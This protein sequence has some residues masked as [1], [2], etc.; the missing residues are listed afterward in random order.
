MEKKLI[1]IN[2]KLKKFDTQNLKFKELI[3]KLEYAHKPSRNRESAIYEGKDL[4]FRKS[5]INPQFSKKTVLTDSHWHYIELLLKSSKTEDN[6]KALNYW[7]QAK[8]FYIATQSLDLISKP[9]TTYY[10]FL[11]AT[12]AL[13]T[14]KGIVF[15]PKHGISGSTTPGQTKLKNEMV[16]L[17]KK[18]YYLDFVNI[19][20]N[21][22]LLKLNK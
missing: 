12:K 20:S 17:H 5:I 4:V 8:N 13:L 18:V 16:K 3:K 14:Y 15:D 11:N 2:N 21:Q 7:L 10:C 6:E 1:R 19:L 22:S 9:L